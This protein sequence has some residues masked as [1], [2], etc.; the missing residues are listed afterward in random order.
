MKKFIDWLRNGLL[1]VLDLFA[2]LLDA[3]MLGSD[4]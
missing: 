1:F 4:D 2:T 3:L